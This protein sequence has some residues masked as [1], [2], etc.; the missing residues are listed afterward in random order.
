[1]S[2]LKEI[3]E[4]EKEC[5]TIGTMHGISKKISLC[6]GMNTMDDVMVRWFASSKMQ[7]KTQKQ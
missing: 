2:Q 7:N 1:M 6:F 5:D 4:R 3:L